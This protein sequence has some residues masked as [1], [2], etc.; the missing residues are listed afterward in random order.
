MFYCIIDFCNI[1]V[2]VQ[3]ALGASFRDPAPTPK[4]WFNEYNEFKDKNKCTYL[5]LY[6][7]CLP[8]YSH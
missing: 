1:A 6:H 5:N 8:S 7:H 3:F 4:N 2:L